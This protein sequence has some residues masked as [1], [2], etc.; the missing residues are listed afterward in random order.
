MLS[1]APVP[2]K[3][4]PNEVLCTCTSTDSEYE[5]R[6]TVIYELWVEVAV[7][8][9]Q[10]N[11]DIGHSGHWG[12]RRSLNPS[13]QTSRFGSSFAFSRTTFLAFYALP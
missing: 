6:E 11:V 4:V 3:L 12:H 8:C 7:N 5:A 1:L 9:D 10:L 2:D 13:V